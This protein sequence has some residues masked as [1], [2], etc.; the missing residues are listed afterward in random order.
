MVIEISEVPLSFSQSDIAVTNGTIS[1]FSGSGTS[2]TFD[3]T[4]TSEG[5]ARVYIPED[6]TITD[7]ANNVSV[8]F[9]DFNFTYDATP[10]T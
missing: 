4:I 1:N 3:F 10:P 8:P 9:N 7:A 6:N 5:S 2:Y